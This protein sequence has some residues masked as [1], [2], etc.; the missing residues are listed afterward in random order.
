MIQNPVGFVLH[1]APVLYRMAL[2]ARL[3]LKW[4]EEPP[5]D[6]SVKRTND[7]RYFDFRFF[8]GDMEAALAT[9]TEPPSK[10]WVPRGFRI[11]WRSLRAYFKKSR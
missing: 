1:Y 10:R 7:E 4:T 8:Q 2:T 3:D 5:T 11:M 6:A 9:A